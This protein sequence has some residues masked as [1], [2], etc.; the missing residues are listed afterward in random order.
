MPR[1]HCLF[2]QS[3]D[4]PW[5]PG[6]WTGFRPET[7]TRT[8]SIEADQSAATLLV[9]FPAGWSAPSWEHWP[10]LEELLVLEGSLEINGST[11]GPQHYAALPPF[12]PRVSQS[13]RDGAVA[14]VMLHGRPEPVAT[15]AIPPFDPALLVRHVDPLALDWDPG[16]VDP[17]LAPGVA[18]KPL[19]T[20]PYSGETTFLYMSPPHRVPPGL[21]KPQWTHSMVEELYVLCGEYVWA[22]CGRMGPGAYVWWREGVKHGPAGTDVGYLLLVRTIGGPLDN[23]FDTEPKPFRWDPAFRPEL[24]PELLA[25]ARPYQRSTLY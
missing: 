20:D 14:L 13:S 17:Q 23:I 5:R 2:I 6:Y 11:Y 8:L 22:D 3:Q 12:Y 10:C 16:L 25:L 24:P 4:L 18:I 7:V 15:G 1:P 19:R 21:A 9:R